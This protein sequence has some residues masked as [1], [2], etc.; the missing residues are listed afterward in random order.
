MHFCGRKM[1]LFYGQRISHPLILT[2]QASDSGRNLIFGK[3]EGQSQV[4]INVWSHCHNCHF[5]KVQILANL[6]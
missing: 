5:N 1:N 4:M 6:D 2:G 3:S